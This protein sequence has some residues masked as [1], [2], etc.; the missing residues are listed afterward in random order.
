MNYWNTN[1]RAMCPIIE[2]IKTPSIS[3]NHSKAKTT[4]LYRQVYKTKFKNFTGNAFRER[5][6]WQWQSL[7]GRSIYIYIYI[8]L[9]VRTHARA[10]V[11]LFFKL[12]KL[13]IW[14]CLIEFCL[15]RFCMQR[16][17]YSIIIPPSTLN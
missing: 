4:K 16:Q 6:V 7:S 3:A 17:I 13:K 2:I 14:P 9:C 12:V 15:M 8:Y 10:C 5:L 11:G 1:V